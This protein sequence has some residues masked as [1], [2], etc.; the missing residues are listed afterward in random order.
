ML[1]CK[2]L[3]E[4]IGRKSALLT[5]SQMEAKCAKGPG[6]PT[7]VTPQGTRTPEW[8]AQT[9]IQPCAPHP[10]PPMCT[11]HTRAR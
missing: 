6:T 3:R 11:H 4:L 9:A 8:P 2:W 1:G 7:K 10:K 5:L